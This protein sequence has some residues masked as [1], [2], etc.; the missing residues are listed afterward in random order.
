V[1][2]TVTSPHDRVLARTVL[3]AALVVDTLLCLAAWR[4]LS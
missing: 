3:G 4:I 2:A 1:V